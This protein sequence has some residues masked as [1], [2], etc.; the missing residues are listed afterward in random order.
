MTISATYHPGYRPDA[1]DAV[2]YAGNMDAIATVSDGERTFCVIVCGET[3]V[4]VWP[5]AEARA[6]GHTEPTIV[7]YGDVAPTHLRVHRKWEDV[8][9]LT[10][11]DLEAAEDR[12]EWVNNSWYEIRP[13]DSNDEDAFDGDVFHVV[14]D[15]VAEI[16]EWFEQQG[17]VHVHANGVV[18]LDPADVRA[19]VC[20][21]CGRAWDDSVS[22]AVTPTP[23]GRCPFEYDHD[24]PETG[25]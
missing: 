24:E 16:T 11:S 10:D 23:A 7:R 21:T 6:D 2:F 19:S 18:E 8:G 25:A 15:A 17:T 12:I 5:T 22:T 20:G 14:D 3:C 1:Q 13:N 9:I 4:Y